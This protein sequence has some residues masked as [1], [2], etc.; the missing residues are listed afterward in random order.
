MQMT[1]R[2]IPF[3][4]YGEELG[5]PK[6]TLPLRTGLDPLA[7]KYRS[8]PQFIVNMTGE[9]L[10]RDECRTPMLWDSTANAGFTTSSSPWLPVSSNYKEINAAKQW[11]DGTSLLRFYTEALKLRNASDALRFGTLQIAENRCDKDVFAYYRTLGN[12]TFLVLL[13]F[14]KHE[15]PFVVPNG[16]IELTTVTLPKQNMLQSFEGRVVKLYK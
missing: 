8:I 2:G 9:S 14:S 4:Y 7:Q 16:I 12:E 1:V 6:P 11:Q 5:I 3:T 10:N 13:N 15:K